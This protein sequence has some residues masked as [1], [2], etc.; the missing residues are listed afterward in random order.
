M[1][2]ATAAFI[3]LSAVGLASL[4]ASD[5]MAQDRYQSP[6]GPTLSPYLDYFRAPTGVYDNYNTFVRPRQQLTQR[7]AQQES[8]IRQLSN[9]VGKMQV[10][11]RGVGSSSFSRPSGLSSTGHVP[12]YLNYS[13]YYSGAGGG[14]RRR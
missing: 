1:K 11:S 6:Y 8:G 2:K 3:F 13:H 9:E 14:G 4:S 7:L 5:A 10:Q 12:G